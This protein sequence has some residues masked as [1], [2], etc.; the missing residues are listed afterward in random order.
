VDRRPVS[1]VHAGKDLSAEAQRYK[2]V[3]FALFGL[4]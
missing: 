1:S 3:S 4:G 2:L